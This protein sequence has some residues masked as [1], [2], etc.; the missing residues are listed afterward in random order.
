MMPLFCSMTF[1]LESVGQTRQGGCEPSTV[2]G[3]LGGGEPVVKPT[4]EGSVLSFS[5]AWLRVR[6]SKMI[7]VEGTA[8]TGGGVFSRKVQENASDYRRSCD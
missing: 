1:V 7:K 6:C 5:E 2:C 3:C 8:V 4:L